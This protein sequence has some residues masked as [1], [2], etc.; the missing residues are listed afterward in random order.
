M[1][2]VKAR[3]NCD[4]SCGHGVKPPQT[5]H[6]LA[7]IQR[8]I[9]FIK[10]Q[11]QET[12]MKIGLALFARLAQLTRKADTAPDFFDLRLERTRTRENRRE[13]RPV[14]FKSRQLRPAV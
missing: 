3:R 1:P 5:H 11:R 9:V 8:Q 6:F 7:A 13:T 2:Q 4:Q 10:V 14:L 12:H